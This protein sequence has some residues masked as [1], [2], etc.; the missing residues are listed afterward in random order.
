MTSTNACIARRAVRGIGVAI[1]RPTTL[2]VLQACFPRRERT[3]SIAMWA[4]FAGAGGA[5]GPIL[6]GVLL[7]HYWYGSVFFIAA[8]IALIA[9]VATLVLAPSS[10]GPNA[11]RPDIVG[12]LL[13]I[14]G[15]GSPLSAILEDPARGGSDAL[16]VPGVWTAC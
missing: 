8:P 1:I 3:K 15:F 2:S 6:G 11:K 9:F 16:A 12:S 10:R 14:I 13:S 5:I 7:A 4:G